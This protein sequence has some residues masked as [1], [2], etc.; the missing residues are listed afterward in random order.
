MQHKDQQISDGRSTTSSQATARP[1]SS[2]PR[3]IIHAVASNVHVAGKDTPVLLRDHFH[4]TDPATP[5]HSD[6]ARQS[7]GEAELNFDLAELGLEDSMIKPE[8]L[9]KLEKIG[10]GGFKEY[11]HIALSADPVKCICWQAEREEGCY[12]RVPR[13]FE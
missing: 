7:N 2:K 12:L 10:S 9:V 5:P 3:K 4:A 6:E 1:R 13:A 8:H 11:V